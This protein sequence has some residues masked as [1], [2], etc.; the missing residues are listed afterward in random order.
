ME[1]DKDNA[2]NEK[3]GRLYK[4]I[5]RGREILCIFNEGEEEEGWVLANPEG[6]EE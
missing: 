4:Q 2:D 6:S 3:I 1:N 5:Y